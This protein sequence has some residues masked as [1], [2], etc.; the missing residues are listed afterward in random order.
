M[1][2]SSRPSNRS[3]SNILKLITHELAALV[4]QS[5]R[6]AQAADDLPAFDIET[7]LIE[8]PKRPEHGDYATAVAIR[9]AKPANMNPHHIATQIAN[10]MPQADFVSAVEVV[11]PGYIN[12]R[13]NEAWLKS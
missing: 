11:H 3:G 1:R 8:V 7:P 2:R 13:L 6:S 10:H 4:E 5:I 9:L 12:F